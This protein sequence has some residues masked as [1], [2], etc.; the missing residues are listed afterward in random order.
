MR[1]AFSLKQSIKIFCGRI[2]HGLKMPKHTKMVARPVL[3]MEQMQA[4]LE[5]SAPFGV[6]TR[7]YALLRLLY[8]VPLRPGELL[9]RCRSVGRH[10]FNLPHDLQRH[11]TEFY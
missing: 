10:H 7:E 9:A 11:G 2:Q 4:L 5:A 6:R 1:E 8:V 3:S